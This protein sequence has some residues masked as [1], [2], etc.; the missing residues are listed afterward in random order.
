MILNYLEMKNR[1]LFLIIFSIALISCEKDKVVAPSAEYDIQL[2]DKLKGDWF[3]LDKPY[4]LKV[5]LEFRVINQNSSEYNSFYMGDSIQVGKRWIKHIYS[6]QAKSDYQGL[7][8]KYD[9]TL[10]RSIA[11]IKYPLAGVFSV[12][13]VTTDVGN[14]GNDMAVAINDKNQIT[15]TN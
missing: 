3:N 7:A 15:V 5:N 8:L 14:N 12:T 1:I 9:N 10:K 2:F 13:F 4:Q 6:E 11:L